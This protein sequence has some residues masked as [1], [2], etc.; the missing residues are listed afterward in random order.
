MHQLLAFQANY[1]ICWN[2]MGEMQRMNKEI[3]CSTCA[4]SLEQFWNG[5]GFVFTPS[6]V[7]T[8]RHNLSHSVD[9]GY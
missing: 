1:R 7:A 6:D 4:L 3:L 8:L 2:R 9:F 5:A